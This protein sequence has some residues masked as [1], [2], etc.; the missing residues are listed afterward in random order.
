M[1]V[2]E[3]LKLTMH[4][5]IRKD[6]CVGACVAAFAGGSYLADLFRILRSLCFLTVSIFGYNTSYTSS[7]SSS[8]SSGRCASACREPTPGG[9]K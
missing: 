6:L 4:H 5:L 3:P 8:S 7:S 9:S 2:G 1:G